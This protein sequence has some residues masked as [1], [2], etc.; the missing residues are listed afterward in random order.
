MGMMLPAMFSRSFAA[1]PPP[2]AESGLKAV[3]PDCRH[4]IPEDARFCPVCGHQQVILSQCLHC[5]KNLSPKA[6]FCSQCG[7]ATEEKVTT[8]H[9]PECRS[10]NIAGSLFCNSCGK[11]L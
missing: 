9:C 5:G 6:K 4:A 3:C 7:R 8:I 1:A 10:E 11:R 2:Q